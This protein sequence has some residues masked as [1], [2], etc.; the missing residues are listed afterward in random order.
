MRRTTYLNVILTVN[1]ALLTGL[2]W[3]QVVGRP[4]ATQAMAQGAAGD[5]ED[6]LGGRSPGIPNAGRQREQMIEAM[7]RIDDNVAALSRTLTNGRIKVDVK[8]LEELSKAV[9]QAPSKQ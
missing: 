4:L 5:G 3:M 2:L 6:P 1:A 9:A 8:N 7:R